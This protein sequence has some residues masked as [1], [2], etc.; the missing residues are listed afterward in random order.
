MQLE[1]LTREKLLLWTLGFSQTACNSP[2]PRMV[3]CTSSMLSAAMVAETVAA[4]SKSGFPARWS[5]A[6]VCS[7]GYLLHDGKLGLPTVCAPCLGLQGEHA[8]E[9]LPERMLLIRA[10]TTGQ[11]EKEY[12]RDI[13]PHCYSTADAKVVRGSAPSPLSPEPRHPAI[14]DS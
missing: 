4:L 14:Q 10:N 13:L 5:A 1:S 9:T 12:L 3:P 2:L 8:D 11:F 6:V 7:D